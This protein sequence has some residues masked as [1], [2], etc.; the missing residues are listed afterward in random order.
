MLTDPVIS[1]KCRLQC[2]FPMHYWN[3]ANVIKRLLLNI[4][5]ISHALETQ[6]VQ[7]GER[8][9]I[10]DPDGYWLE[11]LRKADVCW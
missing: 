8:N 7:K 4:R 2:H 5:N 3:D 6:N 1:L 11:I 9:F 10:V